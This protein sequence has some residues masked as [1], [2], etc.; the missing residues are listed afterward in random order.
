MLFAW[1]GSRFRFVTDVLGVGGIGFF[2]RPGVYSAPYPREDVLLP[3]DGV[4]RRVTACVSVQAR[5]AD[6]GSDLS[7][8]R[9]ARRLRP[10]S[11]MAYG[12]RRAQGDRSARRR[13]ARRCSTGRNG[14][15]SHA[16]NDAGENVTANVGCGRS[17]RCWA[18]TRRSELHRPRTSVLGHADVRSSDRSRSRAAGA[19]GR[20]LGGVPVRANGLRGV[21][22]GRRV[23]SAHARGARL[24]RAAG[25]KWRRS[26][27]ILPECRGR[28]PCRCRHSRRARSALRLRTSQEIYWDRIAVVYAEPLPE[29]RRHVLPMRA[30]RLESDGF[31]RRTTGPQRTP[32]YD[33]DAQRA[34][35]RHAASARLVHRIRHARSARG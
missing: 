17:R 16:A 9:I 34:A 22:G 35:R 6:G 24:A 8:S 13:P 12:A 29:V 20:R 5:R 2:E 3:A 27:G 15:P 23:R 4:L 31:A 25:T 11:R 32:H 26:S 1:D 14:S 19:A 30:A 21:A 7:R 28:W 10:A 18:G 33:D